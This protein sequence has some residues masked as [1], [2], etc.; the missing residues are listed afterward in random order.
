M[1]VCPLSRRGHGEGI[2]PKWSWHTV[3]FSSQPQMASQRFLDPAG[4][5]QKQ[6]EESLNSPGPCGQS[7]GGLR[8]VRED[9]TG[10]Q[11]L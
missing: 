10:H 1:A 9:Q 4:R 7:V 8:V 11:M 6:R 2:R 5:S 3:C